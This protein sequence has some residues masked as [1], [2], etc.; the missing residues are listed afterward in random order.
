MVRNQRRGRRRRDALLDRIS[1]VF[2][3]QAEPQEVLLDRGRL[4]DCLA[5]LAERERSVLVLTFYA[6]EPSS[7]IAARLRLSPEN[8]RTVRHRAFIRLRDCV[9][10]GDA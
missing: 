1:G 8:V 6:E 7:E 5:R 4:R 9:V 10:G 3:R 2:P